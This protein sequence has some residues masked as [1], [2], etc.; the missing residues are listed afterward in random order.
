MNSCI[1]I[2][3]ATYNGELYIDAQLKSL[4]EQS[5]QNFNLIIRDDGSKDRTLEIIHQYQ[6]LYPERIK[7]I[8]DNDRG[9]G[10]AGNF[11]RLMKYSTAS[12]IMFCDQDDIWLENKIEKTFNTIK[13]MEEEYGVD[14]PILVHSDLIV[15]DKNLEVIQQS[16]SK[17]QKLESHQNEFH[18][19]LIQ[20]NITG[21]TMMINQ[22]LLNLSS[23]FLKMQ[24][25]MIG[26]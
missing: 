1:D 15:V 3:L 12:Y 5:F 20:N 17:G 13:K 26:G 19:L 24:L 22:S 14:C 2:L 4:F 6:E 23:L 9:L 21:C 18:Q 16:M 8:T 25:C 10:P 7:V 11:G